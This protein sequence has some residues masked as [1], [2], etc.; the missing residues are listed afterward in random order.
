MKFLLPLIL[1]AALT[2]CAL[3]TPAPEEDIPTI[4]VAELKTYHLTPQELQQ[5]EELF[6]EATNLFRKVS[7]REKV[8]HA[9]LAARGIAEVPPSRH[10][11]THKIHLGPIEHFH[12]DDWGE[13]HIDRR[14]L[15]EA[16][17]KKLLEIEAFVWKH[18]IEPQHHD[19]LLK[20]GKPK[21]PKPKR[22]H[23]SVAGHEGKM[24]IFRGFEDPHYQQHDKLIIDL[25]D[26]FNCNKEHFSGGTPHQA[27]KIGNLTPAMVKAHMIEESGGHGPGSVAA[28]MVDPLQVNVPG[29]WTDDKTLLGLEKP[30]KRNEGTPEQ[31]IRAAIMFLTRKGFGIS[32][33]P[34]SM[35]PTGFFD[36]WETAYRRYNGRRDWTNHHRHYSDEYAEKI[37]QRAKNP[38]HFVPIEI[39]LEKKK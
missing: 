1:L 25:V 16:E 13:I 21:A 17:K 11:I 20:L 36:G 18:M 14:F 26:E 2:G 4:S 10:A 38:D 29:D 12:I 31:N 5:A 24:P 33:H 30:E 27:E 15:S 28:W 37:I 22:P 39:K 23:R 32:A 35:R 6:A 34:A 3:E 19:E 9:Q 8:H 7:E